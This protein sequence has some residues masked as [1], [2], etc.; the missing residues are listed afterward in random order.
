MEDELRLQGGKYGAR[1]FLITPYEQ[2]V[3]EMLVELTDLRV[4]GYGDSE[5]AGERPMPLMRRMVREN[6]R[7]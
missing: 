2:Q 6:T 5:R 7:E 4:G 3:V 1:I